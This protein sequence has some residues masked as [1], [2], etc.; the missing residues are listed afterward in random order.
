MLEA[1][2]FEAAALGHVLREQVDLPPPRLGITAVHSEEVGG[3][4]TRLIPTG[5]LPNL[6][7]DV[8][9]V[10]GILRDERGVELPFEAV[11]L[12][13]LLLEFFARRDLHLWLSPLFGQF[14]SLSHAA[15]GAA[16]GLVKLHQ[17][18]E[19]GLL[20]AQPL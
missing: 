15:L 17:V 4:Q 3:K 6:D 1:H 8:L 20:F 7:D 16:I 12:R 18:A 2:L 13:L 10:G 14:A 5:P 19:L 9:V 11:A